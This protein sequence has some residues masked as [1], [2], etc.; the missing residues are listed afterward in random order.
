MK[1]DLAT[2]ALAAIVGVIVAY[3]VCGLF[4]PEIADV[5]FDVLDS[6]N[7]NYSLAEPNPEIFNYRAVDPTVEVIIHGDCEIQDSNGNCVDDTTN[8]ETPEEA[9]PE[10]ETPKEETESNTEESQ[11]EGNENGST[12]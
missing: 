3:F 11:G 5:S 4:L 1:T 8:L 6:K 10:E 7:L 9:I 2:S 12:D